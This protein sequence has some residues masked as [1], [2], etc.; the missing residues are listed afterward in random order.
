MCK[1]NGISL[2]LVVTPSHPYDDYRLLSLGYWPLLAA[3]YE[4]ISMYENVIV[5]DGYNHMLEEPI[6]DQMTFWYDPIH[7]SVRFGDAILRDLG[8]ASRDPGEQIMAPLTPTTHR[9]LLVR[10][11]QG[12]RL[13]MTRNPGF[14]NLFEQSKRFTPQP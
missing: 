11:E 14:V 4:K 8:G 5:M 12:L 2:H 6:S 7:F 10:R 3:W 1:D 9:A 13:W